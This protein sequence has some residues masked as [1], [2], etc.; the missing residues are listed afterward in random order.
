MFKRP[1]V[2]GHWHTTF[3]GF[4]TS[5]LDFYEL[6][7]AGIVRREIPDLK[8]SEVTWKESGLGSG[9]R[10][11]LRVSREGLN[12]DVCAAPFGTGYFF[13]WWLAVIP[14]VLLDLIVLACIVGLAVFSLG[15]GSVLVLSGI[16]FAARGVE[17]G[18]SLIPM[19]MGLTPVLF[20]GVIFGLGFFIR[21]RETGLEPTV[22]SM[23]VT[24]FLYGF[25]FRPATYFN[26]DTALMFREAIHQ[27]VLEAIDQ[28]TTAQGIRGLSEEA[29]KVTFKPEKGI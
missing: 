23:P 1:D 15:A 28:V 6:V 25:F 26:E 11:Y 3:E 16:S 14:R 17:F 8:I 12:F 21:Y 27:A 19:G 22:L 24:G 2:L 9:K 18:N 13:S 7:K 5:A 20:F 10:V 4:S 29:R